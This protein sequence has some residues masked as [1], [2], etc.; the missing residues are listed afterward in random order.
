MEQYISKS[1]LVAE[2]ERLYNG[3]IDTYTRNI[4]DRL[5]SNIDTLEVKEVKKV[6]FER[7]MQAFAKM[8]LEPLEISDSNIGISITM[9]QLYK[10]ARHFFR[11]GI[12]SQKGEE[13]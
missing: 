4:L 2:I 10:C 12:E 9:A 3:E 8:D 5:K 6:N 11:I 1:A 13:V 7:E